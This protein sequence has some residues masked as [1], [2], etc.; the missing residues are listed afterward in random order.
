M[1]I[2]RLARAMAGALVACA[3]GTVAAGCY[4]GLQDYETVADIDTHANLPAFRTH[5]WEIGWPAGYRDE[6][7]RIVAA[8]NRE[9]AARGLVESPG[10]QADL[11]LVYAVLWRTDA[12]LSVTG[13]VPDRQLPTFPVMTLVVRIRDP[14]TSREVFTARTDTPVQQYGRVS[15]AVLGRQVRDLFEEYPLP[16]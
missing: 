4:G 3:A 5:A 2:A 13:E 16:R 14:R 10:G 15:D 7:K 9:L 6:H 12:D 11:A 8:I 1:W